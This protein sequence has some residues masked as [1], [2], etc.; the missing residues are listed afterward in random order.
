MAEV[1]CII[2]EFGD[3]WITRIENCM[4]LGC[5]ESCKHTNWSTCYTWFQNVG[6]TYSEEGDLEEFAWWR[7]RFFDLE[8]VIPKA[9]QMIYQ[10]RAAEIYSFDRVECLDGIYSRLEDAPC[11]MMAF[12]TVF[13]FWSGDRTTVSGTWQTMVFAMFS[14]LMI[15]SIFIPSIPVV[16]I[17]VCCIGFLLIGILGFTYYL[18]YRLESIIQTMFLMGIGLAV[19]FAVH[20]SHSFLQAKGR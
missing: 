5:V 14:C 1:E 15:C 7:G 8:N 6:T 11:N 12:N 4:D 20:V 17:I 18:G 9:T 16:I 19:D 10:M 2:S 13:P 3:S